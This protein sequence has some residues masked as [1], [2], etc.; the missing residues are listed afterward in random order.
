ML[1]V[2]DSIVRG[3]T[4]SQIVNMVR[5][6]GAAK[7]G[8]YRGRPTLPLFALSPLVPPALPCLSAP[9]LQSYNS[10]LLQLKV[11]LASTSPPLPPP[12]LHCPPTFKVYLASTSPPVICPNVYGVDMP[13]RKEFVA[14][15]LTIDQVGL[16]D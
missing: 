11:Y 15:G 8:T 1:L 10:C 9:S 12:H 13:T 2:D 5:R 7:V 6:A 14:H 16:R 4:M 3:T